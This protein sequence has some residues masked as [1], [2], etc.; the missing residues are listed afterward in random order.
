MGLIQINI[1][2]PTKT[3]PVFFDFPHEN[4][5][6]KGIDPHSTKIAETLK[7]RPYARFAPQSAVRGALGV[8]AAMAQ[9]L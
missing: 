7:Q 9:R 6:R 8:V 3:L 4:D 1:P 2:H 5:V